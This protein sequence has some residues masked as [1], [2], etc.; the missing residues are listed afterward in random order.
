MRA[1]VT[2]GAGFIGSHLV[3][4]LVE[5]GADVVV[6]DDLSTGRCEYVSPAAD[7]V[8]GDVADETV[9]AA[10]V[11]GCDLV[12]HQAA[13]KSVPRSVEH[14]IET[15]RV[16]TG[17]TLTVLAAARRAGVRRVVLASSSSVYGG[18]QHGAT[19][20]KAPLT[21]LS[22]Y[23]VSKLA[24]EHYARLFADLYGVETVILRY[25]N[26]F[27]PRQDPQ[28]QYAAVIP[29]FIDSLLSGR[30]PE[31]YGDGL[32]SRDF[33]FVADAVAANLCAATTPA[34]RCSG[35]AFNIARGE[36]QTVLDLLAILGR[37]LDV[38]I[39]PRHLE[40]RPGDIRHSHADITAAYDVLGYQPAVPFADGLAQTVAWFRTTAHAVGTGTD[41]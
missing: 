15:D 3:D 25:F 19:P 2:G 27:G 22:P 5:Q 11:N 31:V 9:V 35:R 21:P 40:A 13:R 38:D 39:A 23:G 41:G 34:E 14:P 36:P 17:G 4:A 8:E 18:A 32:Q 7:V 1:L 24:G 6:L 37:H 33:T 30:S 28:S 20:E 12:F 10:V 16:N 29:R 26:V